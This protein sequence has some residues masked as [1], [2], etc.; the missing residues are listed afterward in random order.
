[1]RLIAPYPV[2]VDAEDVLLLGNRFWN[3]DEVVVVG[4][5]KLEGAVFVDAYDRKSRVRRL[6][7]FRRRHRIMFGHQAGYRTPSYYTAIGYDTV[8]LL[9]ELL[10]DRQNR[11]RKALARGLVSMKPYSGVTGLTSFLESGEAVKETMFFTIRAGDI[12]RLIP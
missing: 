8:N 9:M 6:R 4:G 2:T 5:Q 12:R 7:T 3:S 10:R 1:L 11:T